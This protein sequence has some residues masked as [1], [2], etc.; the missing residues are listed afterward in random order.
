MEKDY[1]YCRGPVQ[2][3]RDARETSRYH[4]AEEEVQGV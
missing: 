2:H 3:G 1:G 4:G